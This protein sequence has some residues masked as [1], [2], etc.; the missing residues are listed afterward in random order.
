[1][2]TAH[3]TASSSATAYEEP[4]GNG[5]TYV[6]DSSVSTAFAC[7]STPGMGRDRISMPAPGRQSVI[8][9]C[10]KSCSDSA[11][12]PTSTV[13]PL[14]LSAGTSPSNTW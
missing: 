3:S 1:M 10:Q 9:V 2:A 12:A 5:R 14:N 13:L 11:V 7:T 6:R 8:G 4:S